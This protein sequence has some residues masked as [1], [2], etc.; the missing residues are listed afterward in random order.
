MVHDFNNFPEL[1]NSQMDLYYWKSPHKQIT[2]DFT[3][4]VVKV[5]DG[6]TVT[7]RWN[8]RDFDFPI[9]FAQTNAPE[10]SEPKGREVQQWLENILLNQIVD[11]QINPQNRVDKWGRLLGTVIHNGIDMSQM[12]MDL[13]MATPFASRNEMKLQNINQVIPEVKF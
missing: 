12:S 11:I 7:L 3:A 4:V 10:L 6:D 13:G 9:R 1:T 8:Q 5:H 2:E